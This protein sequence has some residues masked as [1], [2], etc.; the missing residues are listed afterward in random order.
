MEPEGAGLTVRLYFGRK[1][2]NK[3]CSDFNK[4]RF[5]S[6]RLVMTLITRLYEPCNDQRMK[7]PRPAG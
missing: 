6:K 1:R 4:G 2:N 3:E 7:R 5:E